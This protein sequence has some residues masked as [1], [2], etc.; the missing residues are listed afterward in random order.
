MRKITLLFTLLLSINLIAQNPFEANSEFITTT[1]FCLGD[2][3]GA[4]DPDFEDLTTSSVATIT[5]VDATSFTLD[6][7]SGGVY[8][9]I[10]DD[11]NQ[12]ATVTVNTADQTLTAS[13]TDIYGD[14]FIATG[15]YVEEDGAVV[16]F[17]LDWSNDWGDEG[18]TTYQLADFSTLPMAA[19]NPTPANNSTVF[20]SEGTNAQGQPVLQFLF[21]WELPEDSS[22]AT[23][24]FFELGIESGN[25]VFDT[26]LS[27]NSLLLSG[28][29]F[30]S[31][32]FWRVTP[33]NPE[34]PASNP[35]EWVFTTEETLSNEEFIAENDFVHFTN[36]NLLHL[37]ANSILTNALI[38]DMSGRQVVSEKINNTNGTIDLNMLSSGMYI[39]RVA[40]E[41]ANHSF[42]I[43]R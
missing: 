11:G 35:V 26:T 43:V 17:E 19:V 15:T 21:G 29:D 32:Y 37:Q 40:T 3:E 13:F 24:F 25:Y 31:T 38:F 36:N 1:N 42:K 28:L 9:N 41:D 10:Y 12:I 14:D 2:G 7:I 16:S 30:D 18:T 22:D 4:C 34:G 23:E 5:A 6:D 39:V 8:P 27:S 33:I 20:L